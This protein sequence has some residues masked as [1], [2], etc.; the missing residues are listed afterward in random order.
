MYNCR[1]GF[2]LQWSYVV[3]KLLKSMS[4]AC[5]GNYLFAVSL[6]L[7]ESIW[8][9]LL[10]SR[11]EVTL[12]LRKFKYS[13]FFIFWASSYLCLVRLLWWE[14]L[15]HRWHS[16]MSRRVFEKLLLLLL[17][18][19]YFTFF[20]CFRCFKCTSSTYCTACIQNYFL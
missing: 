13:S 16:Q 17:K 9:D 19:S 20:F 12:F 15:P 6:E 14:L 11:G 8:S 7:C 4:P 18:S 1:Y 2:T 5:R 3:Q 10:F